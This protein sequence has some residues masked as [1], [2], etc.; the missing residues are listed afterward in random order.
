MTRLLLI[1]GQGQLGRDLARAARAKGWSVADPAHRE[2]DVTDGAAIERAL[3]EVRPAIVINC[4]AFHDLFRCEADEA[5]AR[6]VNAQAVGA[7][8]A[9]CRQAGAR[10]LAI[11]TDYVFDGLART[12][13]GEDDPP[14]PLQ[15]YGRSRL[16]GERAAL[17]A[18]PQGALVVRTCGLYGRGGSQSR[19]SNFVEK[20]LADA[21][22]TDRLDVGCD[23]VCT[24]TS[25]AALAPAL[26]AL[27]THPRAQGGLY[28]LTAQGQCS[29]AEFTQ[30]IFDLAKVRCQV[31]PIDRQ[32]D[33]GP[34]RRPPYSVLANRKAA[35]L[36]IALGA[37]QDGL[38]AYLKD[39]A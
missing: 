1:G 3:N 25:T 18:D 39:R 24:P 8:A 9:A 12:P 14:N 34:I 15:A 7:L 2:L 23:L 26:L 38:A 16:E 21:A 5:E 20:R 13:Y 27:A 10:L 33:Y 6:R 11:S 35:G 32:G 22:K 30:A 4:A 36:G 17:A 29:W 31:V 19:G 28:H 37:W